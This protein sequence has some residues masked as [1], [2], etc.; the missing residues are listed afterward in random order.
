MCVISMYLIYLIQIQ[1]NLYKCIQ[2][3]YS[4]TKNSFII[5]YAICRFSFSREYL[6]LIRFPIVMQSCF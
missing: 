1:V 3:K 4:T 5:N 2:Y 6:R